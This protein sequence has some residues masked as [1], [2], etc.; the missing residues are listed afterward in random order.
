MEY[1]VVPGLQQLDMC[2]DVILSRTNPA[3]LQV[4]KRKLQISRAGLAK[5]EK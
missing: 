1:A 2:K 4:N 3:N 5:D